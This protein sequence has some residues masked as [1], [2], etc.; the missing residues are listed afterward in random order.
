[1]LGK[2]WNIQKKH[3]EC[4]ANYKLQLSL[5]LGNCAFL[6]NMFSIHQHSQD[7]FY[8]QDTVSSIELV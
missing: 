5:Y 7:K 8:I 4:F 3:F 1:M 6:E 2:I